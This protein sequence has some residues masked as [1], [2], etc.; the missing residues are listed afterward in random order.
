MRR[1]ERRATRGENGAEHPLG[2]REVAARHPNVRDVASD[3]ERERMLRA[4]HAPVHAHRLA[5][6]RLGARGVASRLDHE[7][8][9]VERA[10]D[11]RVVGAEQAAQALQRRAMQALGLVELPLKGE[12]RREEREVAGH[13]GMVVAEHALPDDERLTKPRLGA[14]EVAAPGAER[15]ELHHGARGVG[16]PR[17]EPGALKL[18]HLAEHGVGGAILAPV[19]EQHAKPEA[20]V[21]R[22]LAA[23]RARRGPE[24]ERAPVQ[25][26]GGVVAGHRVLQRGHVERAARN[27]RVVI[28][29]LLAHRERAQQQ[30]TRLVQP[31]TTVQERAEVLQALRDVDVRAAEHPLAQLERS[32]EELLRALVVAEV[33]EHVPDHAEHL[34]LH[35]RLARQLLDAVQATF[36]ELSRRDVGSALALGI[37]RLEQ[38]EQEPGHLLGL[39]QRLLGS[40]ARGMGAIALRAREARLPERHARAAGGGQGGGEQRDAREP[41]A[42]EELSRA[43]PEAVDVREHGAA[44]EMPLDVFGELLGGLI[45]PFRLL[46]QRHEHD[47]VEVAG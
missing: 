32:L 36:D 1:A 42:A 30:R 47:A 38:G 19:A 18:E 45:S 46:A 28:Q 5:H 22:V 16:A 17:A 34:R 21:D 24:A 23:G 6:E 15:R 39:P 37:A 9:A 11:V 31:L 3:G 33:L 14:R 12:R 8:E 40:L 44:A 4:A 41:V 25:R 7:R 20:R 35:E 13:L 2:G 29:Q 26:L 27:P 10:G 43:V